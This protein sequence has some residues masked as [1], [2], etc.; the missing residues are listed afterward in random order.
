M[1]C[2]ET[3]VVNVEEDNLPSILPQQVVG[4]RMPIPVLVVVEVVEVVADIPN[5][6]LNS[7]RME[8]YSSVGG[9]VV[10]SP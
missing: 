4:V 2:R 1:T 6:S 10:V 7:L 8:E 5:I 3:V 9:V